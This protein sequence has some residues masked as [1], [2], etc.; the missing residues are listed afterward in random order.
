[1][2][3]ILDPR[4]DLGHT[5][6]AIRQGQGQ[7]QGQTHAQTHTH[8]A[9]EAKDKTEADKLKELEDKECRDCQ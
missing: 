5:D 3:D 6:R 4:R 9:T 7:G 1:M 2:R 8:S